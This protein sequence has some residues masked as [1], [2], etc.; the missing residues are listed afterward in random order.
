[1]NEQTQSTPD[2]AEQAASTSAGQKL[3]GFFL[4]NR[5]TK[6]EIELFVAT[7]GGVG[8]ESVGT[9]QAGLP[10]E[11]ISSPSVFHAQCTQCAEVISV[12]ASKC[13]HCGNDPSTT[14]YSGGFATLF[15]GALLAIVIVGFV[16]LIAGAYMIWLGR[17]QTP[18]GD[19]RDVQRAFDEAGIPSEQR[20]ARYT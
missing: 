8:Y 18:V 7:E 14:Y 15:F 5:P 12:E 11:I 19:R 13:P 20:P 1:M 4:P 9:G 17:Y 16:L 3:V 10:S 6:R 2:N